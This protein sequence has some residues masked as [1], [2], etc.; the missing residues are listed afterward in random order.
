MGY[1]FSTMAMLLIFIPGVQL[2]NNNFPDT[3]NSC[4]GQTLWPQHSPELNPIYFIIYVVYMRKF[5]N[6]ENTELEI[7]TNLQV[8]RS[9]ESKMWFLEFCLNI[10]MYCM[11]GWMAGWMCT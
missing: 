2:A 9:P 10:C 8:F 4:G 7:L 6:P 11:Y 1:G 5:G 3:W